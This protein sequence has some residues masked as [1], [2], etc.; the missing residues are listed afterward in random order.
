[1]SIGSVTSRVV[2]GLSAG[3]CVR[4]LVP[5]W[6]Y[7]SLA[8]TALMGVVNALIGE[9]CTPWSEAVRRAFFSGPRQP[10]RLGRR[11]PRSDAADWG[12]RYACSRK[13]VDLRSRR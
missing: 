4:T 5:G 8:M 11:A 13:V 1:M 10:M 6:Q 3:R 2:C 9:T 7:L 12:Y